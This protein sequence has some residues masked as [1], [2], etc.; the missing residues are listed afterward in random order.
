MLLGTDQ[1]RALVE[2]ALPDAV[3]TVEDTTGTSDHFEMT[4]ISSAFEGKTPV[5]RQR[6]VFRA[7]GTA[8][9]GPIHA[10]S[11]TTLTPSE[12]QE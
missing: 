6:M 10:L 9:A 2:Q 7:L 5:D 11:L 8:M 1:I 3:V 12:K 4:V